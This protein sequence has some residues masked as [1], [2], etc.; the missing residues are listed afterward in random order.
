MA[1]IK[2]RYES[3]EGVKALSILIVVL[4]HVGVNGGYV[5]NGV[6]IAP[7]LRELGYIIQLFFML[8]GFG[9]CCGYY[10]RFK[11]GKIDINQFYIRRY[12]NIFPLFAFIVL[13]EVIMSGINRANL[14]EGFADLTLMFGFLPNSNIEIVGVGWT[15]G[16]IFAFYII[17]PFFVFMLWNKKRAWFFAAVSVG[18]YY[19][20]GAYFLADGNVV[21]CNLLKWLLFFIIGGLIYLHK[22][23]IIS[24]VSKYRILVLAANCV[25]LVMTVAVN[26]K[27]H[28]QAI[29]EILVVCLFVGIMIYAISFD[30]SILSAKLLK[31][32]GKYCLEIYL[33]HMM[34]FR[35]LEKFHLTML[36]NN[37]LISYIIMYMVTVT[38]TLMFAMLF[39]KTQTY[40][41]KAYKK[42]RKIIN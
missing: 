39:D 30:K 20:C 42:K 9:M 26:K 41:V 40:V 6:Q 10:N 14:I 33:A 1:E 29:T 19:V 25:L 28:I 35:V 31:F 2:K 34:V 21:M 12:S 15:L 17:F 11:E 3:I 8:S 22:E 5:I 7:A 23:D 38:A 4:V 13:V 24:R 37:Q 36:F 27:Y 16:I 32:I 18:L